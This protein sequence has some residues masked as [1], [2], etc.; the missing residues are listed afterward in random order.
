M[1]FF[2]ALLV[3]DINSDDLGNISSI[4]KNI[5]TVIS[6]GLGIITAGVVILAIAIAYKFFTAADENARKNAKQQ[7]IYAIVGIIVLLALLILAPS[8]TSAIG[9]AFK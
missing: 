8:V 3:S 9:D 6:A 7:L 4:V 2:K 5:N 1:N